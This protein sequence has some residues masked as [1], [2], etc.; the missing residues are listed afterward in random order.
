MR[1]SGLS[2][3]GASHGRPSSFQRLKPPVTLTT[4][5]V[6]ELSQSVSGEHAADPAGAV[7][8]DRGVGVGDPPGQLHLEV[9]TRDVDGV[10]QRPLLELVRLAHVERHGAV[11]LQHFGGLGRQH[12][13]Y[14][15][16]GAVQELTKTCHTS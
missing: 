4:F 6:P 8:D 5:G 3:A 14:A 7:N 9:A 1:C 16:A 15:R 10:L 12:F 11:G 2:T 13:G